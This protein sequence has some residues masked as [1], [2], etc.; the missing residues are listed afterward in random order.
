MTPVFKKEDELHKEN[1]LS[2]QFQRVNIN[3]NFSKWCKILLGVPHCQF[4]VPFYATFSLMTFSIL[5]KTHV[6]AILLMI[7]MKRHKGQKRLYFMA[8]PFSLIERDNVII[9][10]CRWKNIFQ[11]SFILYLAIV[12]QCENSFS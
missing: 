9:F 5:Y 12:L 1:Y 4:Y 3:N 2:E 8:K 7:I 11:C 6:F 10:Q